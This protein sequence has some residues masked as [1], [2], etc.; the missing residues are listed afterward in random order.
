MLAVKVRS[1]V[2]FA[3]TL[4]MPDQVRELPEMAGSEMELP[5]NFELPAT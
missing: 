5:A 1:A 2:P 3:G 4:K